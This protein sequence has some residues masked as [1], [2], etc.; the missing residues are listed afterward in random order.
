[1]S[2]TR[3]WAYRT[4]RTRPSIDDD[5]VPL[6]MRS[7]ERAEPDDAVAIAEALDVLRSLPGV[8]HD[9]RAMAALEQL[10]RRVDPAY[11]GKAQK[12]AR[13]TQLV[14]SSLAV[15]EVLR[16]ALKIAVDVLDAERG[17]I[18]LGAGRRVAVDRSSDDDN[19]DVDAT[20][21]AVIDRV[22]ASGKPEFTFMTGGA[23]GSVAC[24]P[25]RVRDGVI[26]TV[27]LDSR[28]A[29]GLFGSGDREMLASFAQQA[30]L[31]IDNA[32]MF[33]EE[34][35]RLQRISALQAFQTRI[36]EAIA[37]GVIT[38]SASRE[39]TTFN[40]AAETTFGTT[41]DDMVGR[42]AGAIGDVIPEFPELLDTF[43]ESG[44]VKLRAEVDAQRKDG[45]KLTLEMRLSPLHTSEGT[46]AA[47][48]VTDVTKQRKLEEAH[49]AEL[50]KASRIA[51][52][53]SRYLAPHVVASLMDDP[54]SIKLGGERKRA[55]M[56]FADVRG[57]T[58]LASQLSPERVVDILNTYFDEAVRVVFDHD[59]LLDKFYGDGLMAVFGPPRVRG[60]DATRA[61]EAAIRLHDRVA[62]LGPRLDY[63][64]RISVGLATGDVVAGHFGS[65]KRMDYTVIGD[66]VNLASG[67]QSAAPPGAIYCDEETIL[68]TTTI[69]RPVHRLKARI[70]GRTEL[71]P[72]YAILP[73][74]K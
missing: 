14:N 15:D 38:L 24:M 39:I 35:E 11:V 22:V 13:A 55:T 42:P 23:S 18:V 4:F 3:S 20:T 56:L 6:L 2:A 34:R 1:M 7:R 29:T 65:A 52:S 25:L 16:T 69:S 72:A 48:V 37:N 49:E 28:T 68:S 40:R 19:T 27:Y 45:T 58:S 54:G 73:K 9:P 17:F 26:G 64:L 12:L 47:M 57:F 63:P 36:L 67:L 30:A 70:K 61:V 66:A 44:A 21:R 62:S 10:A 71:V 50:A 74:I 46:G 60:D 41:S 31:A 53:F 43:F 59:G 33:E 32:R 5:I 8:E 51:E